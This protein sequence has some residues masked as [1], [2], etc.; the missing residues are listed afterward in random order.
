MSNVSTTELAALND[1]KRSFYMLVGR[2]R[3]IVFI[4][5]NIFSIFS[6]RDQNQIKSKN[7]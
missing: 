1:K 6:A 4:T 5:Y 3:P 2:F 7:R